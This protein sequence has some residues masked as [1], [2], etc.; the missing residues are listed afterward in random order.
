MGGGK[1]AGGDSRGTALG[2]GTSHCGGGRE[3]DGRRGGGPRGGG[4]RPWGA[5]RG[6]G[7]APSLPCARSAPRLAME[8]RTCAARRTAAAMAEPGGSGPRS[9][10]PR[11]HLG[12]AASRAPP[13]A[14]I[15]E[16]GA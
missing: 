5:A 16:S 4:E 8:P 2:E 9:P 13:S 10:A 6:A 12:A 7:A 3:G 15:L 1:A 14:A 11:R